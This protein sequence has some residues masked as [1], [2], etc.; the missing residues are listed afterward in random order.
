MATY[1]NINFNSSADATDKYKFAL[2][3]SDHQTSSLIYRANL[4]RIVELLNTIIQPS[5][6]PSPSGNMNAIDEV[7]T[8]SK[9]TFENKNEEEGYFRKLYFIRSN[10]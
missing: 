2:M 7:Q 8:I 10:N 3:G 9:G 6:I 1:N 5:P 4:E